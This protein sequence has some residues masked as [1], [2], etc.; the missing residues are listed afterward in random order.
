MAEQSPLLLLA[1]EHAQAGRSVEAERL[2]DEFLTQ[3]PQR[4]DIWH[5]RG[6]LALRER[7]LDLA[8]ECLERAIQLQPNL[9]RHRNALAVVCQARKDLP[10]AFAELEKAIQLQPDYV[11][12]LNNLGNAYSESGKPEEAV[13]WYQAALNRRPNHA[14]AHGNLGAVLWR[15]G[16]PDEGLIHLRRACELR[17]EDRENRTKLTTCLRETGRL[18]E[19]IA[20][21]QDRL[22]HWPHDSEAHTLLGTVLF[23]MKRMTE[24]QEHYNTALQLDADS[25]FVQKSLG[26]FAQ[27]MGRVHESTQ[28]FRRAT[29]LEPDNAAVFSAM[30]FA[31][32]HDPA[33][34]PAEIFAEHREYERRHAPPADGVQHRNF[35]DP[36]RRLR[37]GYVSA[38]FKHH[39]M[40]RFIEPILAQ[41]DPTAVE[42]YCY[43]EVRSPDAATLHYQKLVPKWRSICGLSDE[44]AAE[45]I[46]EDRVDILIDLSG[47]TGGNRLPLFSKRPAPVQA[48]F[49]GYPNTTGLSTI[50]YR[51]SDVAFDPVDDAHL[52]SE[53]VVYL[54]RGL[55]CLAPIAG[56]PEVS[57]LP[58]LQN[59]HITFGS[60]HRLSKIN[61]SVLDLWSQVLRMVPNSRLLMLRDTLQ[62]ETRDEMMR[63]FVARGVPVSQLDLRGNMHAQGH[64][65]NFSEIDISFDTFPYAGGTISNESLWMGVPVITLYGDRPLARSGASLLRSIGLPELVASSRDDYVRI[66]VDLA[67]DLERLA[68]I[69]AELRPRMLSTV[70]DTKAY[71]RDLEAAYRTMWRDWCNKRKASDHSEVSG[72]P[73]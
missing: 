47:H 63:R 27:H 42:V 39:A 73:R 3:N 11:E 14:S 64:L 15:L 61:E 26:V 24:A 28:Y 59:N 25:G 72:E 9:P 60:M 41:H 31:L 56:A 29:E 6:V 19:A 46:A 49:L 21:L 65:A 70:C 37:V 45:I 38:D 16:R 52:S 36:E 67:S 18:D 66:V 22:R 12:A 54:S 53:R 50:D 44:R 62:G 35:P 8:K 2:Y 1:N 10:R 4:D 55:S 40:L 30:L 69:R 23:A 71:T 43:S 57:A 34:S 33:A 17:P 32:T 68:A 13:P 7:K 5:Q 51:L 48:T 58:A 20:E